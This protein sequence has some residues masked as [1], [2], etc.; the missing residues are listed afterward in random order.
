MCVWVGLCLPS[1]SGFC[2][3]PVTS[4]GVMTAVTGAS[5]YSKVKGRTEILHM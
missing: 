2:Y 1:S 4:D 3:S 5:P